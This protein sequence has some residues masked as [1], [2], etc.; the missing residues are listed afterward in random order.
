MNC[1]VFLNALIVSSIVWQP[2]GIREKAAADDTVHVDQGNAGMVVSDTAVASRIGRQMLLKDGNAVDAAVATAFALA[3]SWPEAGNI[4][5]GGF[6]IIRPT[7][8]REAVCIDYREVAPEVMNATSF[9]RTDTRF[10]Q[11]AVG[12]PGTVRG[13]AEAHRRYGRLPWSDVVMPAAKL[14]KEGVVVDASLARS[15]N[16]VLQLPSVKKQ[17][18]F[19]ELRRVYGTADG[20]PW[21]VGEKL[22]LPE[23]SQT[24]TDIAQNGADAFY[25]GRTA[26]LLVKEMQRGDGLIS[27]T[28]LQRYRAKVRPAMQGTYR[29]YTILGAPPPSS[30]GVCLIQA[31]NILENFDLS[32]RDRFDPENIH[33]IAETCRRVFADRA[34]YLGDPDFTEIPDHLTSKAYGRELADSIQ[35]DRA[36]KSESIA[37]EIPLTPES[38]DTTHFS[39]IDAKGMSVSNTYTLEASWGSRMVVAGAGFVLNNEMGDFNWFPGETNRKG[40]IGTTANLVAPG[41]R[42]LSSQTP[43]IVEKDGRVVLIT[44][45]PGGRTIINTVLCIVLGVTEFSMDAATAVGL[46]R[47]HHQWFPDQLQLERLDSPPHSRVAAALRKLGHTVSN[48]SAQGS[49][50]SIAI[51][52]ETRTQYGIADYRRGGRPAAVAGDRFAM[53]DFAEDTGQPLSS[54][55]NSFASNS[56]AIQNLSWKGSLSGARTD[57]LDRLRIEPRQNGSPSASLRMPVDSRSVAIELK[58]DSI[59]FEGEETGERLI[60]E[61]V[62]SAGKT[63]ADVALQRTNGDRLTL[64]RKVPNEGTN[65]INVPWNRKDSTAVVLRLEVDADRAHQRISFRPAFAQDWVDSQSHEISSSADIETLRLRV[66]G[67]FRDEG[68]FILLDRIDVRR[69]VQRWWFE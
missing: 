13:L 51:D 20:S 10:T 65:S 62:D 33:L 3:V 44:G 34:R 27:L 30:G 7:D 45:S 59:Q 38:E 37:P 67:P 48:R 5:G 68:E 55:M 8:G 54:T 66:D 46:P 57:G 28:D 26:E 2:P 69:G 23:L 64:N 24:L 6:M 29:G 50:H 11:K 19:A 40:R 47:M 25:T 4:G 18:A 1:R 63:V 42:M 61:W 36:S 41:K 56:D 60:V 35:R 14:A 16:A 15:I 17:P 12:V 21:K 53:W 43:T 58:I 52:Q 22:F 9:R 39:V 49:A 31:L 32:S